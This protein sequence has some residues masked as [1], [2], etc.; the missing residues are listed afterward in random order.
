M[1]FLR[2]Y[3]IILFLRPTLFRATTKQNISG[4]MLYIL[5]N[6]YSHWKVKMLLAS[7]KGN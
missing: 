5:P 3:N 6:N 4:V 1:T 7:F 2:L